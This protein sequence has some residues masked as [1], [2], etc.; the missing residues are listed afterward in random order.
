M[1][2]KV[3]KKDGQVPIVNQFLERP[4]GSCN[5]GFACRQSEGR[6][7]CVRANPH[8]DRQGSGCRGNALHIG[9][10]ATFMWS[11]WNTCEQPR[12]S[13]KTNHPN[14]IESI[15]IVAKTRQP[16]AHLW[17]HGQPT[18]TS[19]EWPLRSSRKRKKSGF[20]LILILTQN[21]IRRL[22]QLGNQ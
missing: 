9:Q 22:R 11:S 19:V 21:F 5:V 17:I 10:R 6:Q 16:T 7:V 15:T 20:I 1:A 4:A 8:P 18:K 12:T 14:D 2:H 13:N 3:K